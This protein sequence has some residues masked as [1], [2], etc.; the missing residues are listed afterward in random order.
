MFTHSATERR[1]NSR[2]NRKEYD[3]WLNPHGSCRHI[4]IDNDRHVE[5]IR[6]EPE[7]AVVERS[8]EPEPGQLEGRQ[9]VV[10]AESARQRTGDRE[11]PA[12]AAAI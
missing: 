7:V 11:E 3:L 10:G 2:G 5:L 1:A 6:A 9:L 8:V 12:T 4:E